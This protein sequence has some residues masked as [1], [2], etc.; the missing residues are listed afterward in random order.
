MSTATGRKPTGE[1]PQDRWHELIPFRWLP[2]EALA[3]RLTLPLEGTPPVPPATP[4]NRG[5]RPAGL[6]DSAV[7]WLRE[8]P[9]TWPLIPFW[10]LLEELAETM[11][12]ELAELA[13]DRVPGAPADRAACAG[14][15]RGYCVSLTSHLGY[16]IYQVA[17]GAVE[18]VPDRVE[19]GP[20]EADAATELAEKTG[21]MNALAR[22]FSDRAAAGSLAARYRPLYRQVEHVLAVHARSIRLLV[23][24]FR[25]DQAGLWPLLEALPAPLVELTAVGDLHERGTVCELVFDGDRALIYKPHSLALD[26]QLGTLFDAFGQAV[27]GFAP[28]IPP[29]LDRGEHGWQRRISW[30]PVTS[31]ERVDA[32]YRRVGALTALAYAFRATDLHRENVLCRGAELFVIDPECFF[33]TTF[34]TAADGESEEDGDVRATVM[35]AGILPQPIK[36]P[37]VDRSFDASVL[38]WHRAPGMDELMRLVPRRDPDGRLQFVLQRTARPPVTHLPGPVGEPV[39]VWGHEIAV[40]EGF[41]RAYRWL[42]QVRDELIA[43][44]GAL[45]GFTGLRTRHVARSTAFYARFLRELGRPLTAAEPHAQEE[46]LNTLWPPDGHHRPLA[47]SVFEHERAVLLRGLIPTFDLVAGERRLYLPGPDG[48][49]DDTWVEDAYPVSGLDLVRQRLARLSEADL[50]LQ[51]RLLRH[52]LDLA[53]DDNDRG[54]WQPGYEPVLGGAAPGR[55]ELLD[56]AEDIAALLTGQMARTGGRAWWPTC[57]DVAENR[58]RILPSTG[59]LYNGAAGIAL[60]AGCLEAVSGRRTELAE[61]AELAMLDWA[62]RL[63]DRVAPD[64]LAR[65]GRLGAFD[66]LWGVIYAAGCLG[67]IRAEKPLLRWAQAAVEA[68]TP[69]IGEAADWDVISGSA[70]IALVATELAGRLGLPGAH[71]AAVRAL[72]ATGQHLE[73]VLEFTRVPPVGVAHG[74]SGAALAFDRA[75]RV[76]GGTNAEE[77]RAAAEITLRAEQSAFLDRDRGWEDSIQPDGHG[78]QAGKRESWCRGASGVGLVLTELAGRIDLP[79]VDVADRLAVAR[80]LALRRAIGTDHELC[81]GALGAWEF[82]TAAGAEEAGPALSAILTSGRTSGWLTG[83]AGLLPDHGLM[84]GLAGIGLGLLRAADPARVPR[85][86]T[87]ELPAGPRPGQE[88]A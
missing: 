83:S 22:A 30:R 35:A 40:R 32:Y 53:A 19:D 26:Q 34:T 76:L 44:T 4:P 74:L 86:L 3:A 88:T 23:R 80:E 29:T 73:R 18:D 79:G 6:A 27:P 54:A 39:P 15:T 69:G 75:S 84:T 17:A 65:Q 50:A 2:G 71:E 55:D 48:S 60:F 85:V 68:T 66:G 14:I 10:P 25:H 24:R 77:Y 52:T 45:A 67:A 41:D 72:E 20:P 61:Q 57:L 7:A 38:G 37:G 9:A 1:D 87:L 78:R 12:A 47:R 46:Q 62:D 51:A 43:P 81:H 49:H 56:A 82:L 64:Q 33:G 28:R 8:T 5:V 11:T 21:L 42:L 63:L 59:T 16:L 58:R 13:E 31:P 70:G 36:P